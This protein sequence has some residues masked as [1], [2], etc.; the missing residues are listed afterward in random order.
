MNSL[1][2]TP[3]TPP[4]FEGNPYERGRQF[5]RH[6]ADKGTGYRELANKRSTLWEHPEDQSW[7]EDNITRLKLLFPEQIEYLSG[8]ADEFGLPFKT[9][10]ASSY[11][12]M[13]KDRQQTRQNNTLEKEP[14]EE[15]STFAFPRQKP[16]Q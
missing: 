6:F 5:A 10:F 15:C 1:A 13:L 3:F 7:L 4:V 9:L 2:W 14:W 8:Q 11:A 12:K 16:R